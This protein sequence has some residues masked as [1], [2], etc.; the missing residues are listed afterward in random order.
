MS[1]RRSSIA[2]WAFSRTDLALSESSGRSRAATSRPPAC[3]LSRD[4]RCPMT[5]CTSRAMRSRSA[6]RESWADMLCT[7]ARCS[8]AS[9]RVS[10]SSCRARRWKPIAIGVT[11][12]KRKSAATPTTLSSAGEVLVRS[13]PV[14]SPRTIEVAAVGPSASRTKKTITPTT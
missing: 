11:A 5:S 13:P 6:C 1:E 8:S 9:L 10:S 3:R 7:A 14:V 2:C 4:S 12:K